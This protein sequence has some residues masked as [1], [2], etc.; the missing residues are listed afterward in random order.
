MGVF[1]LKHPTGTLEEAVLFFVFILFNYILYKSEM[2]NNVYIFFH[3]NKVKSQNISLDN[4][5][6]ILTLFSHKQLLNRS[7]SSFTVKFGRE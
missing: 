6:V 1:P 4:Y 5:S 3:F 2:I 7:R